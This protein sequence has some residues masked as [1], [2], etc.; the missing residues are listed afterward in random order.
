MN[1]TLGI[2]VPTAGRA[3]LRRT[4]ESMAP[5]MRKGDRC[6]VVGDTLD[7]PL[8][9]TEA[10]VADYPWC[11]YR[12][13]AG[14]A[15]TW[16]HEQ[17]NIGLRLVGGDWVMCQDDDDIYVPDA[18]DAIRGVIAALHRPR[19]LLFRFR[20]YHN[21]IV[22]WDDYARAHYDLHR[23]VPEGHIGGHCLVTPNRPRRMAPRGLHYQGDHTWITDTLALWGAVEPLWVDKIIA[24]ARPQ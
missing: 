4:L 10:I 17:I 14:K 11:R 1:P 12:P 9:H 23:T 2:V 7:G 24:I 8:P 3:S 18:F 5:Q 20:S 16:G 6:L 15:H 22:Y 19:P 21:G 13:H